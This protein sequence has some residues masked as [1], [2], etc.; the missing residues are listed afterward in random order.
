MKYL[1]TK[2]T[3]MAM[4]QK[5]EKRRKRRGRRERPPHQYFLEL[6]ALT[7]QLMM[8]KSSMLIMKE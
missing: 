3:K 2:I 8:P 7:L 4:S 6:K 5:R 1:M